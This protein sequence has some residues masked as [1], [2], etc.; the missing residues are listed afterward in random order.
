[1]IEPLNHNRIC[2]ISETQHYHSG[3]ILRSNKPGSIAEIRLGCSL[4]GRRSSQTRLMNYFDFFFSNSVRRD[5]CVSQSRQARVLRIRWRFCRWPSFENTIT[6]QLCKNMWVLCVKERTSTPV[7][8]PSL[9]TAPS[10]RWFRLKNSKLIN[11]F[12]FVDQKI[13]CSRAGRVG[14]S[15]EGTDCDDR[16]GSTAGNW[17]EECCF[18]VCCWTIIYTDF[19]FHWGYFYCFVIKQIADQLV[20]LGCYPSLEGFE[21]RMEWLEMFNLN[22]VVS[23][24]C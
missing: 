9:I 11:N 14:S 19:L 10:V 6:S 2:A 4:Y 3:I 12:N 15:C 24:Q 5:L 13:L 1:M 23:P 8:L 21:T 16:K 22:T 17:G 18:E 20:S 7:T